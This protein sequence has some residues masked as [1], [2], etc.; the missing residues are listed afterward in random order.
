MQRRRGPKKVIG[1]DISSDII[2]HAQRAVVENGLRDTVTIL[3][4]KKK[5]LG[6]E[7]L[8]L[9]ENERIDVIISEWMGS[10]LLHGNKLAT[11]IE[12]RDRLGGIMFPSRTAL[13]L[14]GWSDKTRE[15]RDSGCGCAGANRLS[16]WSNVHGLNLS[17][18]S[19]LKLNKVSI[20]VVD[21]KEIVTERALVLDLDLNSCTDS[22]LDFECSFEMG[23]VENSTLDG[24]V[25]AFDVHFFEGGES[26]VL[27]STSAA[28]PQT[29][30]KQALFLLDPKEAPAEPL[31]AG[32]HVLGSFAMQ[33]NIENPSD[34]DVAITWTAGTYHGAQ[35]FRID[36]ES[37]ASC[38]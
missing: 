24:F 21:D 8:E 5:C 31:P 26:R 16:W 30:W 17:V 4:R 27:L 9:G 7:D 19:P 34:Y 18:F 6:R 36:A 22:A 37:V 3:R 25:A 28:K 2:L 38:T 10:C 12:T 35:A 20:E 29:H 1:V 23:M 33:R 11:I 32:T 15:N 13:F 14:N